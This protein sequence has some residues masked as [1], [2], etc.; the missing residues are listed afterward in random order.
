MV[1]GAG[2]RRAGVR[3]LAMVV[4]MMLLIFLKINSNQTNLLHA[5][6]SAPRPTWS[7]LIVHVT[8]KSIH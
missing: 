3:G 8:S 2:R 7:V 4:V 6:E 5:R 1:K